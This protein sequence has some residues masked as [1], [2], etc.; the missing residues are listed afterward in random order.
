[1]RDVTLVAVGLVRHGTRPSGEPTYVV[2]R[3]ARGTHLAGAW[4]FPGGKVQDHENPETALRRELREELGVDTRPATPI[5]FAHHRYDDRTV[6][7]LL[8]RVETTED[9]PPPRPVAS[10]ELRLVTLVELK[11]LEFPPANGPLL[12]AI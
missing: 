3:R 11:A 4:E 10:E 12:D 9:S 2:T 6:L 1:M 5:T 7:L 8:F